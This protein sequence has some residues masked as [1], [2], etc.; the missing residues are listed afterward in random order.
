MSFAQGAE[1][2]GGRVDNNLLSSPSMPVLRRL[3]FPLKILFSIPLQAKLNRFSVFFSYNCIYIS[4][5]NRG[6]PYN[7]L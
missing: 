1:G 6:G 5:I 2:E 3:L 4:Q 7:C